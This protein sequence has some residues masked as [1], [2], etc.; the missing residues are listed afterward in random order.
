M[1]IDIL[2]Q[3]SVIKYE[4]KLGQVLTNTKYV[5]SDF[6]H[7]KPV[8]QTTIPVLFD[9]FFVNFRSGQVVKYVSNVMNCYYWCQYLMAKTIV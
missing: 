4:S 7:L 5:E 8:L 2:E 3:D 9:L 1:M 6:K